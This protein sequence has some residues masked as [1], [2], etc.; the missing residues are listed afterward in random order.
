MACGNPE[1]GSQPL[2]GAGSG[3]EQRQVGGPAKDGEIELEED[4]EIRASQ[5]SSRP[6]FPLEANNIGVA[7]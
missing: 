2:C 7:C 4:E 5:P 1:W 6:D 3:E